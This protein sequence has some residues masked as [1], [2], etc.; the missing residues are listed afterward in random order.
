MRLNQIRYHVHKHADHDF[1]IKTYHHQDVTHLPRQHYYVAPQHHVTAPAIHDDNHRDVTSPAIHDDH[2]HHP[3]EGA[4]LE[5]WQPAVYGHVT[6]PVYRIRQDRRQHIAWLA[7]NNAAKKFDDGQYR[8]EVGTVLTGDAES[9]EEQTEGVLNENYS[10]I[11][12][13]H[14]QAQPSTHV[15]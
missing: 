2:R 5:R 4:I 8:P 14:K 12:D 7:R 9:I 13:K 1:A 15:N 6:R 11:E 3:H 10:Y